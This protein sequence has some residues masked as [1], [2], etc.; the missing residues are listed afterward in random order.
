MK[1]EKK[2]S[3]CGCKWKSKMGHK[4]GCPVCHKLIDIE[5]KKEKQ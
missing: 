3:M 4:A 2:C 5:N 1:Q